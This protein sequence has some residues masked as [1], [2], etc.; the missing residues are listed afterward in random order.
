M[1]DK[2]KDKEESSS[3]QGGEDTP[4]QTTDT[5]EEEPKKKCFVPSVFFDK[6]TG[7]EYRTEW[8]FQDAE[9]AYHIIAVEWDPDYK[10]VTMFHFDDEMGYK[11]E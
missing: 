10:K 8:V 6:Q 5:P 2:Q 3:S 9:R 11:E 7:N 1:I 4:V